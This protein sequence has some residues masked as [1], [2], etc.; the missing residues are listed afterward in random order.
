MT[1]KQ[2]FYKYLFNRCRSQGQEE[3]RKHQQLVPQ[4]EV[5]LILSF[6]EAS[7][8]NVFQSQKNEQIS[9]GVSFAEHLTQLTLT[10]GVTWLKMGI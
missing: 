7:G 1:S 9:V 10:C 5:K 3:P 8:R 6:K 2:C 4:S